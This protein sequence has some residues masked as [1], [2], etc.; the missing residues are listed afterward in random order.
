[1]ILTNILHKNPLTVWRYKEGSNLNY[2]I[3]AVHEHDE[4]PKATKREAELQMQIDDL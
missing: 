4:Q 3:M 2:V 1:M